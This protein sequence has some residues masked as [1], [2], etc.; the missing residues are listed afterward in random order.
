M[1][2][3]VDFDGV[4]C[5]PP[6]RRVPA[7]SGA[8]LERELV[9]EVSAARHSLHGCDCMAIA[10]RDDRDD[11]LFIVDGTRLAVVHLTWTAETD[12]A[13][14]STAFVAD[15]PTFVERHMTVDHEGFD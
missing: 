7:H 4:Q 6:W 10:R 3:P 5:L 8:A 12:P 15:V 1:I 14:P 2:T 13:W 9:R 11:V